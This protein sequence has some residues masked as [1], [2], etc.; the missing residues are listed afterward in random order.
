MASSTWVDRDWRSLD[1]ST[2]MAWRLRFVFWHFSRHFSV[3]WFVFRYQLPPFPSDKNLVDKGSMQ[4]QAANG[5]SRRL[6]LIS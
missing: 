1:P 5:R 6:V 4:W 2:S 3:P